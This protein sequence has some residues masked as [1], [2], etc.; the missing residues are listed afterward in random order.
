M[1]QIVDM[2]RLEPSIREIIGAGGN[3]KLTVTGQ[4]MMPTLIEHR[5]SVI[6]AQPDKPKKS[7]IV[8]YQR[9]NGEYVLHRIVKVT[10]DG[11]G[12]CGDNQL[13]VEYPVFPEQIIAVVSFIVR[14]G[15]MIS[16]NNPKYKLSSF[17]WTNFIPMRPFMLKTVT[18][19][20]T[21]FK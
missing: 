5:D 20:K 6:L 21:R 17:I 8:L 9:T 18:K 14:K 16:K 3:V 12:M 7:D 4:S 19:M 10:K 11:F 2:K 13:K 15:E 1:K